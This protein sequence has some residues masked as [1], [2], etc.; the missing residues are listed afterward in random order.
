MGSIPLDT[1]HDCNQ[2]GSVLATN[3]LSIQYTQIGIDSMLGPLFL[4]LSTLNNIY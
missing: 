3:T 1:E 4:H 2:E